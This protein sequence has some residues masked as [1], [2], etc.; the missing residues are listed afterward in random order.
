MLVE[1]TGLVDDGWFQRQLRINVCP[2]MKRNVKTQSTDSL[3]GERSP[4]WAQIFQT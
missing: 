1:P 3:S 4:D 2:H